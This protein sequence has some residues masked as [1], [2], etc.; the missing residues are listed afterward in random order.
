MRVLLDSN[1]LVSAL[2]NPG[3]SR[4]LLLRLLDEHTVVSSVEI[5]AELEGVL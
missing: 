2:V 5:L 3:A 1:V 4:R